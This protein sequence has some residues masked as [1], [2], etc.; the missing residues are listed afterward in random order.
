MKNHRRNKTFCSQSL[1]KSNKA[2][3]LM[4]PDIP[5]VAEVVEDDAEAW[6][7]LRRLASG[8]GVSS[9]L[10]ERTMISSSAFFLL[11]LTSA[12]GGAGPEDV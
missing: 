6:P 3:L 9:S 5:E 7:V 10:S 1:F 12:G 11:L 4:E 2:H 8:T